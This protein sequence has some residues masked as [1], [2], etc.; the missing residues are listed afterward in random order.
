ME[1]SSESEF[2]LLGQSI[3]V[4]R[5]QGISNPLE[6]AQFDRVRIPSTRTCC[7]GCDCII[8]QHNLPQRT[9]S[10]APRTPQRRSQQVE[11]FLNI[12]R[13]EQRTREIGG[14]FFRQLCGGPFRWNKTGKGI[15]VGCFRR[16]DT[17]DMFD[18]LNPIGNPGVDWQNHN[19]VKDLHRIKSGHRF[20]Q[21]QPRY[22]SA[23]GG[24]HENDRIHCL[25]NYRGSDEPPTE[26]AAACSLMPVLHLR[27]HETVGKLSAEIRSEAPK[28]KTR[29]KTEYLMVR[30]L[31][32]PEWGRGQ[33]VENKKGNPGERLATQPRPYHA[34][35]LCVSVDFGQDVVEHEHKREQKS[36][37]RHRQGANGKNLRI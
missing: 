11:G 33:L 10:S 25:P 21:T 17:V 24:N 35:G 19:F 2:H 13:K 14:L 26:F 27:Q 6:C 34:A 29:S 22:R 20:K 28:C 31:G 12:A 32:S 7:I 5:Y 18:V 3:P 23:K 1:L 9:R 36:A 8:R 16:I 37:A 4:K 30:L 15:V